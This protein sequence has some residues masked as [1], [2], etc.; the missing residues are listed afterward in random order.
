[1][2]ATEL[3]TTDEVMSYLRIT[4]RTLYRLVKAQAIPLLRVG[5]QW[6]F[7]RKELDAWMRSG[8][9]M[10]KQAGLRRVAVV[11]RTTRSKSA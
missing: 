6:R 2:P 3:L 11:K 7:R 10:A 5:H 4:R 1:M 9:H 8:G